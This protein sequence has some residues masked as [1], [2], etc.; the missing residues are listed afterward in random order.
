MLLNF[1]N[2]IFPDITKDVFPLNTSSNYYIKNR[3]TFYTRPVKPVYKGIE[4]LSYFAPKILELILK[5]I[6]S[7]YL[8]PAFK[9]AIKQQKPKDCPCRLCRTYILQVG[10]V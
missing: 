10:F 1:V 9:I 3:L 2:D 5:S 8:L 6:K 7:I 4:S